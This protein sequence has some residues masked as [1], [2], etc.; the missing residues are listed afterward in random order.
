MQPGFFPLFIKEGYTHYKCNYLLKCKYKTQ[1]LCLT[2]D[3]RL[4]ANPVLGDFYL[5][6]R[7]YSRLDWFMDFDKCKGLI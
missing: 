5:E 2:E 6:V 3:L 1:Q 7:T 4:T